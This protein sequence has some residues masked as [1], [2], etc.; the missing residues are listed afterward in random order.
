MEKFGYNEFV[1]KNTD[2]ENMPAIL[3]LDV[4]D[5]Q[6]LLNIPV[7]KIVP[8][9]DQPRKTFDE[10]SLFELA[11]SIKEHGIL[12]PVTVIKKGEEEYQIVA[13]ERRFRA[14]KL[15]GLK[16]IPCI[17][18]SFSEEQAYVLSV[19][20]N[21]Q[22]ND[23]TYFEEA[24]SYEKLMNEYLFTQERLA[25]RLGKTQSAVANKL[26]L[27]K[28]EPELRSYF[29]DNNLTERHARCILKLND[30]EQ[31]EKALKM[32]ISGNLNVA[33]SEALIL[34]M[35]EIKKKEDKTK[36]KGQRCVKLFKD[37]RIFQSTINHTIDVIKKAGLSVIADKK[38]TGEFIEYVIRVNKT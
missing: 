38:E 24:L 19:I 15:V 34:E 2:G 14:A 26:R 5:R 6:R 27:L 31:R 16:E 18:R 29:I 37:M 30:T 10:G 22:R 28:I 35:S 20:E 12:Q 23:L 8:N 13:G 36:E 25:K 33:Q 9:P 11:S 4:R 17:L 32:I 3:K 21:I 7:G 1:R